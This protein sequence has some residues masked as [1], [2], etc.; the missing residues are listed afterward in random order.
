MDDTCTELARGP[1]GTGGVWRVMTV[2]P[3]GIRETTRNGP[4]LLGD[5]LGTV[6]HDL[7]PP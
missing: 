2:P 3:N 4:G 7:Q 6:P 5:F 1:W